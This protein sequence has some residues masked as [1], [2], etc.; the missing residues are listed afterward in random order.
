MPLAVSD[1]PL[2]QALEQMTQVAI[3]VVERVIG[4]R[5]LSSRAETGRSQAR[6]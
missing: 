6:R 5:Q 3:E 1:A 4:G 2:E